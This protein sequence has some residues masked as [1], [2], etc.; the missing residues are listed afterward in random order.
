MQ[1][2]KRQAKNSLFKFGDQIAKYY[3]D[4]SRGVFRGYGA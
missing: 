1:T 4:K 3:P 2:Q